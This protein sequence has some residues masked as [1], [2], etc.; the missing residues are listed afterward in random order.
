MIYEHKKIMIYEHDIE[1]FFC[2]VQN[3]FSSISLNSDTYL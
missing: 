2:E 1:T 3:Y